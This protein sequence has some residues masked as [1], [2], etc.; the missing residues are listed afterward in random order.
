MPEGYGLT[1]CVTASCLTPRD[2]SREGSIGIPFPDTEYRIVQPDTQIDMPDGEEGEIIL[3]G[4]SVMLGYLN[5]IEET[6]KALRVLSDGNT[7]LYTGDLGVKDADGYIY[8]RQRIK[9]MIVS[10]GYNIYPSQLENVIDSCPEVAYSCVIGV[11]DSRRMSRVRAYIVLKE[12]VS[13]SHQVRERIMERLRMHV[14]KYALPREFIFRRELPLT[15]VGKVA[16]RKLEEEALREMGHP[17][18]EGES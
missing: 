15:L 13:E 14:A 18:A 3:R 10:N 17:V 12:N 1:E 5:N 11:P 4:P 9:R 7:W 2:T 8:F 6:E 16:Y